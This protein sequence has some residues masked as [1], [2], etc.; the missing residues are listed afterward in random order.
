VRGRE[1]GMEARTPS[2]VD[3]WFITG[4]VTAPELMNIQQRLSEQE[5]RP[6][7]PVPVTYRAYTKEWCGFNSIHY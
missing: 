2:T 3:A 4:C 6:R 5:E 1:D 7:L